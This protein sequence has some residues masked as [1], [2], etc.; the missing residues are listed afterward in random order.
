MPNTLY[1][2]TNVSAGNIRLC[3]GQHFTSELRFE[4]AWRQRLLRSDQEELAQEQ[5]MLLLS[6]LKL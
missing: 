2:I 6:H 1:P 4:W 3:G 5:Y